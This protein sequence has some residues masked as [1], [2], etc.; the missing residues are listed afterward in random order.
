MRVLSWQRVLLFGL[1]AAAAIVYSLPLGAR[2]LWNQDE[3]R[4]AL[5][6]EDSLRRG[7][8]LPARVRAEPYLNKP[9][10]FFWSVALAGRPAGHVSERTASI[11]SVVSAL[12]ALGGVFALG[13]HL[14]GRGTGLVA[15]AVLGT[16]PEFFLESHT[17]LPDMM[18]TAWM[19]WSL[20][21]L[22]LALSGS[23]PAGKSSMP[24]SAKSVSG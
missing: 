11:P 4:M 6:A 7:F 5:I 1:L 18:M 8:R 15:L 3:A 16:S 2:N 24:P 17:V 22:L 9:P 21:F 12:A 23:T 20:Y 19:T 14:S 13:R 10:L